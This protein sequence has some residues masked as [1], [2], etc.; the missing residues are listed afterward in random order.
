LLWDWYKKEMNGARKF[1]YAYRKIDQQA[2]LFRIL[3][4][5]AGNPIPVCVPSAPALKSRDSV[6]L[7]LP[8]ISQ[9][10]IYEYIRSPIPSYITYVVKVPFN[11]FQ[12]R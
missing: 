3:G 5:K 6:D 12:T 4:R 2:R 7:F 8:Y 9:F 1:E 11:K 10:I